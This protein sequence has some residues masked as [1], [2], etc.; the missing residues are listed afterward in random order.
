MAYWATVEPREPEPEEPEFASELDYLDWL[1][2]QPTKPDRLR[3]MAAAEVAKYRHATLKAVAQVREHDMAT[4]I[5]KARERVAN[6][7]NVI[8]LQPKAIEHSP[9]ELR[10]DPSRSPS[11]NGSGGFRRRF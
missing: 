1:W 10:P 8:Q 7:A 5:D 6:A 11:A 2:K 9:E 3:F 4:I